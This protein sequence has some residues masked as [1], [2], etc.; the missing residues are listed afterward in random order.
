MTIGPFREIKA[1]AAR[2]LDQ[3]LIEMTALP[4]IDALEAHFVNEATKWL[5]ADCIAWNNWRP[6]WSGMISG[7]LNGGYHD[8]FMSRF[9][10]FGLTV[11]HHP[12]IIAQQFPAS[13]KRVLR[14]S[15]FESMPRFRENPLFREVYRH[16]DSYYQIAF[17][18]CQLS[19]RRV[20]L[21]LNRRTRDFSL[22]EQ[23]LLGYAGMRLAQVAAGI[24]KN[25]ALEKVWLRLCGITGI[26]SIRAGI[27]Q[28]TPR[29]FEV[30]AMMLKGIKPSD[31]ARISGVRRDTL[32]KRLGLI[33]SKLGLENNQQLLS[34]LIELKPRG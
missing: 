2:R 29:D 28:L 6:D 19:D 10:A 5:P 18:P 12:V 23:Q 31:V 21:T 30:L 34:A 9:D 11:G 17:T 8:G 7:R 15:D 25:Q 26:Q 33:R 24:E 4:G 22:R 32:D 27:S 14:L 20:L 1:S 13:S 3:A 16:I